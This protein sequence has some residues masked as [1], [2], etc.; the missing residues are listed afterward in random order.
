MVLKER[1]LTGFNMKVVIFL[2]YYAR[3]KAA[4]YT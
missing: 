3:R 2:M 4:T 1:I